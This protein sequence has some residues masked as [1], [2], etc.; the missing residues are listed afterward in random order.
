MVIWET[1]AREVRIPRMIRPSLIAALIFLSASPFQ[2]TQTPNTRI[3]AA[4]AGEYFRTGK[5]DEAV[6]AF[7]ASLENDPLSQTAHAG[8]VRSL[9]RKQDVS[10]ARAAAET[11]IAALPN[12]ALVQTAFGDVSYRSGDFAS[13]EQAYRAA[14]RID[15]T[16]S[17]VD[18]LGKDFRAQFDVRN[19]EGR[20]RARL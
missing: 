17:S 8:L 13:A 16:G 15:A 10:G 9:I 3:D 4:Q 7:K 19:G 2:R 12:S 1:I 18:G 14:L 6:L 20:D 5:F 11:A